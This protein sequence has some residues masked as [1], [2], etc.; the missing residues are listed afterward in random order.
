[1]AGSKKTK[2]A[3]PVPTATA[4]SRLD[5]ILSALD[6]ETRVAIWAK[7]TLEV[8]NNIVMAHYHGRKFGGANC[9]NMLR[10]GT[11][12]ALILALCK[13]FETPRA[14]QGQ[15]GVTA[16]NRSDLA[17]IPVF[18]HL[19]NQKRCRARLVARAAAGWNGE[20]LGLS[21]KWTK[22]CRAALER[23]DETTRR[24]KS[25][26]G[27]R[28]MA[29]LAGFRDDHVAHLYA[30]PRPWNANRYNELFLLLDIAAELVSHASIVF[31][32]CN[33][34]LKDFEESWMEEA[35]AFWAP[36]LAAAIAAD[37]FAKEQT[38]KLAL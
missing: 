32:G 13:L 15:S 38:T 19:L 12:T 30:K 23:C 22:D 35:R 18:L 11:Q 29:T 3:T 9:Y 6:R 27:R 28:A 4:M 8:G 34:D 33:L 20:A 10:N 36:A 37:P 17:S 5:L 21:E 31:R 1:M 2:R 26:Q 7:V 16:L 24:L 14:R 25:V